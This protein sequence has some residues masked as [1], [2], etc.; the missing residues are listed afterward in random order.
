MR[1]YRLIYLSGA[2]AVL[3]CGLWGGSELAPV[4]LAILA[5]IPAVSATGLYLLARGLSLSVEGEHFCHSGQELGLV[6]KIEYPHFR[7]AGNIRIDV[8]CENHVFGTVSRDSYMLQ[9]GKGRYHQFEIF[10]DT[11]ACGKRTIHIHEMV[12][13]DLLGLFS[14]HRPV[15]KEF[16]CTVY[17]YEAPMYVSLNRHREREQPGELYDGKKSGTDVSEVFGLREYREGDPLQSIHWKLSGKMNQL[18]VREF[19]RPVNYHTM[20]LISPARSN[21]NQDISEA[22]INAVFDLGVSLSRA[23]LN[24]N[25]A[26][27][28]GYLSGSGLCCLPVDSLHSYEDMLLNLMN[29][30]VQKNGDETLMSFLDQQLYRQYTKVVYVTA[31]VNEAAA[32]NLSVLADLTILEATEGP[33]GY[34]TGSGGYT[35]VGISIE[36]IRKKEH[37]VP[38]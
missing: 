24:Q 6:L 26:H 28:T 1:K 13:Y 38:L 20:I 23:L 12:C 22:G 9:L 11:F 8:V 37:I 27:F 36:N 4:L 29:H 18:I 14:W 5:V 31:G 3:L 30:P 19:G 10:P 32:Q 2:A 16:T 34:Q 15:E 17:P 7:P 35:V 21:G 25:M 33:S